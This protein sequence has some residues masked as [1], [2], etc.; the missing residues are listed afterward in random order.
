[1]FHMS[2]PME[3]IKMRDQAAEQIALDQLQ[4]YVDRFKE[5]GQVLFI[6]ERQ[7]LTFKSIEDVPLVHDYE[8]LVLSEM[9]LAGNSIYLGEFYN[10]LKEHR[11]SLI[12]TDIMS[13]RRKIPREEAFA[14]ENNLNIEIVVEP[15]MC[16]YR[17][18]I[19]IKT[20]SILLWVPRTTSNCP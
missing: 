2:Q 16:E 12:I 7:L 3:A 5:K 18:L 9:S 15:L 19:R 6:A 11:F 17:P 4:R 13:D 20:A 14:E 1:M 10:D 8:N